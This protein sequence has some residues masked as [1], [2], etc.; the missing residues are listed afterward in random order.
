MRWKKEIKSVVCQ[1]SSGSFIGRFVLHWYIGLRKI[2]TDMRLFKD[3]LV[4]IFN[5]FGPL[6]S[7]GA[8][9]GVLKG[10]AVRTH[11]VAIMLI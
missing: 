9:I 4:S 10:I 1:W 3:Q 5:Y 2:R 8:L 7:P 6:S 11:A